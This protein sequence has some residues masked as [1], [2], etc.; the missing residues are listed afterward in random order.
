MKCEYLAFA[1]Q[2]R[3]ALTTTLYGD[4]NSRLY[5]VEQNTYGY[6]GNE[7]IKLAAAAVYVAA[8]LTHP[9]KGNSSLSEIVHRTF[10]NESFLRKLGQSLQDF[11]MV[12]DRCWFRHQVN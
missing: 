9:R 2:M 10:L 7:E 8:M 5:Y 1:A 12:C 4:F 11:Y 3:V 6:N